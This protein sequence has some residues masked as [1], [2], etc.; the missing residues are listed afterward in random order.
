LQK[1]REIER[2]ISGFDAHDSRPA[3][4][5]RE[6]LMSLAHDLRAC[7]EQ[8]RTCARNRE[9]FASSLRRSLRTSMKSIGRSYC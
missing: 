9:S 1:V 3:I 8:P 2:R 4:P 7:G 5:D 6:L